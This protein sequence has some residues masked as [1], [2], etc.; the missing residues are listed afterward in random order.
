[1]TLKEHEIDTVTDLICLMYDQVLNTLKVP[2]DNALIRAY[3]EGRRDAFQFVVDMLRMIDTSGVTPSAESESIRCKE[4]K[5]Y[6]INEC[7]HARGLVDATDKCF[8][9]YAERK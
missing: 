4:C 2:E 8:C 7:F 3:N 5:Y 9:S 1:M 6:G